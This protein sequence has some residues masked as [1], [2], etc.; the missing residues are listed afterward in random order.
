MVENRPTKLLRSQ[1]FFKKEKFTIRTNPTAKREMGADARRNKNFSGH[2]V[3]HKNQS[4]QRH[5]TNERTNVGFKS[6]TTYSKSNSLKH[7]SIDPDG[8]GR[9]GAPKEKGG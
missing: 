3:A 2:D 1:N 9:K 5:Q 6:R 8:R 7:R 4:S